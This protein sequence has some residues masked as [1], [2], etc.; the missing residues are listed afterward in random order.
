[1]SCYV[2]L[3][4]CTH[5]SVLVCSPPLA[6]QFTVQFTDQVSFIDDMC[7]MGGWQAEVNSSLQ[8]QLAKARAEAAGASEAARLG[9]ETTQ[10][11]LGRVAQLEGALAAAEARVRECEAIRKSLHNTILVGV[12]LSWCG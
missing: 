6:V 10:G 9:A 1:M 7:H 5:E 3:D 12:T 11:A 8:Q 4:R 2:F